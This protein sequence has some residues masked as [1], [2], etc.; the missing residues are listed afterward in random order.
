M[1][2][3]GRAVRR[4]S[5]KQ[6]RVGV[7]T[8]LEMLM[9]G[10]LKVEELDDEEINRMQLRNEQG[11]F[12]GRPPLWVPREMAV[13][14]QQEFRRRF[15]S[16]MQELM[17]LALKGHEELLRSRHLAPGD[18]ARMSAIKEVYERTIGKVVQ[19]ADVHMTVEKRN[20]EDV[21][22]D[23]VMDL[24]IEDAEEA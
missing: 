11:D 9:S 21:T 1:A 16:K 14:F 24:D 5:R 4:S 19:T 10:E 22:A 3:P 2:E 18:A 7:P 20:F 12:R 15:A 13:A 6:V 17:P 8:R 23:V